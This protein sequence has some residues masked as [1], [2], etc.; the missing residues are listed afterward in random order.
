MQVARAYLIAREVFDLSGFVGRG[1]GAG[2][3]G[4]D[5]RADPALPGVP[6][7]AGPGGA[8]V[9][10]EPAG[11]GSTSRPRSSGSASTVA[12]A[13]AAAARAAGRR[14]AAAAASGGPRS[15]SRSARR[16]TSRTA[17]RRLLDAFSLLDV[18]EIAAD[19]RA[20]RPTEVAPVYFSLSE[21]YGVDAM[22]G[23]DHRAA[24]RGPLGRAGPG[25]AA[26]RPL[27]RAGVAHHR[28]PADDRRGR[29]APADRPVGEGQRRRAGPGPGRR[30]RRSARLDS[31]GIAALSVALRSLRGRDPQ[32]HRHDLADRPD[33]AALAPGHAVRS[34]CADPRRPRA[35]PD[36][37][38]RGRRRVAA[39][40]GR[41]L[42]AAVRPLLRRPG[43][44]AARGRRRGLGRRR[45]RAA[46]H[47]ADG[48]L[49]GPGRASGSSAGR[50]PQIDTAYD[51]RRIV[52]E[53]DP[54]WNDDDVPVREEA[55][56]VV[57]EGRPIAVLTRHTNLAMARMPSRLELSYLSAADDLARMIA[58]GRVPGRGGA[59]RLAARR[60]ARGRR[61][62]AARRRGRRRL[63]QPERRLGRAPDRAP[64]RGGRRV[65]GRGRHAA[66]PRRRRRRREPGPGR[67][68]PRAVAG[69]ARGQRHDAVAA[70]HPDRPRRRADGGAGPAARRQ[71][72]APARA[73]ADDQGRDD[74]GDPPPGE[75][76]PADRGRA[77]AAAGPAAARGR[78]GPRRAGGGRTPGRRHRAGAPDAVPGAG[79]DGGLRRHR[80]P[81][82][83][84]ADRGGPARASGSRSSGPG[85][86]GCC[87][88]RT[89]RRSRWC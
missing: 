87:G 57:R 49:R 50:R 25:V 78:R 5:R 69:R 68:R 30:S 1:R 81:E 48:L 33:R 40:A 64:G 43:A 84:H 60:A 37:A 23:P 63:R 79:R 10:P 86:S 2:Q 41:R 26:D 51:E 32:R 12:D 47:R 7:A 55:I 8:L 21:R 27:R 20:R 3:P 39:P 73:R 67:P 59:D 61:L 72:A 76:Q 54:D 89:R 62:R 88:P 29:A 77:A 46:G 85:R 71:R 52:R 42:A 53:R 11:A 65:P 82:P 4:A 66:D 70:G 45:A 17:R 31:S 15:W 44:L 6:P 75:E 34:R 36:R 18:T 58:A 14:R 24:P 74:P 19:D 9:H 22:L 16:T 83:G 56:P 38:V 35:G 13:A 80:G 28:G